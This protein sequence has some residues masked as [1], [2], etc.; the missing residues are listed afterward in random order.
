MKDRSLFCTELATE[1]EGVSFAEAK[2]MASA[3]KAF[4]RPM[5]LTYKYIEKSTAAK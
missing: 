3:A 2:A 5:Y 1:R 4:V